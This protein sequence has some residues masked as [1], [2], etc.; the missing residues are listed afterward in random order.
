MPE[1]Q[2]NDIKESERQDFDDES[3]LD[4]AHDSRALGE[5]ALAIALRELGPEAVARAASDKSS[6]T[7]LEK[8][9]QKPSNC[10]ESKENN[11]K[12]DIPLVLTDEEIDLYREELL[13][14]MEE[15]A[16]II[17]EADSYIPAEL[18]PHQLPAT[19]ILTP[20]ATAGFMVKR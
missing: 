19:V 17:R 11:E 20:I 6:T 1:R 8:L 3:N 13:A 14:E 7:P 10:N 5:R 18:S 2:P 16:A 15:D 9:S 12:M 4:T